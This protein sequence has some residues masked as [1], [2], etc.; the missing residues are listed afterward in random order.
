MLKIL[1]INQLTVNCCI[2]RQ[3]TKSILA[4]EQHVGSKDWDGNNSKIPNCIH[5]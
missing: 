1:Q 2:A 3:N 4:N 5:I